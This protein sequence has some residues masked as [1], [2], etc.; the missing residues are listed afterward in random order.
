LPALS[1]HLDQANHNRSLAVKLANESPVQY[2]DWAV[3]IA[4]YS[5]VHYFEAYLTTTPYEHSDAME[6]PHAFRCSEVELV[7]S[8]Q[9][10]KAYKK[11]YHASRMLRYLTFQRE[12]ARTTKGDYLNEKQVMHKVGVELEC[13][14]EETLMKI[15]QRAS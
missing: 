9:A 4:F 15:Q 3:I 7:Y 11:L 10:A 12:F 2:K 13:F 5:A 8:K 14:R 6:N 1:M